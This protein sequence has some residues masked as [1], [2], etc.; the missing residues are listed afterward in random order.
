MKLHEITG[1][2][3]EIIDLPEEEISP[4][5]KEEILKVI[6][7][8]L[9]NKSSNIIGYIRN[10]ELA[11][12][13]IKEEVDRLSKNKKVRE[14]KLKNFKEYVIMCLNNAGVEK[15]ETILG[16]ISLRKAPASVEIVDESKIPLEFL[17]PQPSKADKTALKKHLQNGGEVFGVKLIT[18]KVN[19]NIK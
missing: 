17:I 13:A 12:K 4:Q 7:K 15:V 8:E 3:R 6:G 1:D 16:N 2:I 14:N 10:E 9:E 19:L 11:I 5:Q 18:D